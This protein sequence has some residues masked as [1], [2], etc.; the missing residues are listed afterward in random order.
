MQRENYFPCRITRRYLCIPLF[1]RAITGRK[2]G[3]ANFA[4]PEPTTK[5]QSLRDRQT[6]LA[7]IFPWHVTILLTPWS[8]IDWT[9]KTH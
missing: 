8:N 2:T 1:T 6:L 3:K 9:F 4:N 5:S 7:L